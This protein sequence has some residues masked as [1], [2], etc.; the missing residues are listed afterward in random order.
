MVLLAPAGGAGFGN[1]FKRPAEAVLAD[2]VSGYV[3]MEAAARD[4]GVAVTYLGTDDQLV[5]MPKDYAVDEAE[6][7][8][9]RE[10]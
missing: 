10:S 4:Y 8:R 5:R 1:P 7:A 2:V 9:L 3:S 6:T